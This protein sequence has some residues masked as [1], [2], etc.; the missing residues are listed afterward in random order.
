MKKHL[1]KLLV[2][3][4]AVLLSVAVLLPAVTSP[5]FAATANATAYE[6]SQ[7]QWHDVAHFAYDDE[8]PEYFHGMRVIRSED[9]IYIP[10]RELEIAA[11]H[12]G[13]MEVAA[14]TLGRPVGAVGFEG[15]YALTNP[16]EIVE[17]IVRFRT[18]PAVALRLLAE[19]QHPIADM[20]GMDGRMRAVDYD[21]MAL[22]AHAAFDSQLSGLVSP[23]GR[24][25]GVQIFARLHCLMN[26]VF[27]TVPAHMVEQIAGLPEVFAV[28]PNYTFYIEDSFEHYIFIDPEYLEYSEY[29]E[30]LEYLEYPEY[31]E[32]PEYLE[33][34]EYPEY[35]NDSEY[36]E[37]PKYPEYPEYDDVPETPTP[38]AP[39][40]YLWEI[41]PVNPFAIVDLNYEDSAELAFWV[42]LYDPGETV[43]YAQ[44]TWLFTDA[45]GQVSVVATGDFDPLYTGYIYLYLEDITRDEAG[46]YLLA[47]DYILE[48]EDPESEHGENT[49]RVFGDPI[50]L[51][52]IEAALATLM[53]LNDPVV[54]WSA[55]L[56]YSLDYFDI[57]AFRAMGLTG[58]G[59]R[60]GVVDSGIDYNHPM[61]HSQRT[62]VDTGVP[63][64]GDNGWIYTH[65][66]YD[67]VN[68]QIRAIHGDNPPA[69]EGLRPHNF[70]P[71]ETRPQERHGWGGTSH[72]TH[73]QGIIAAVAPE[74]TFY[75]FRALA[76]TPTSGGGSNVGASVPL[77]IAAAFAADVDVMNLSIGAHVNQPF[78]A[79][80]AMVNLAAMAGVTVVIAAGNAGSW[81]WYSM[82][83]PGVA[84]LP[85][86]VGA[87]MF[88]GSPFFEMP[89]FLVD[90][91]A[92]NVSL[93]GWGLTCDITALGGTPP[94]VWGW[95][96]FGFL[97][98]M[99]EAP[100]VGFD[101]DGLPIIPFNV[102]QHWVNNHPVFGAPGFV[103]PG[104]AV[105]NRGE[106]PLTAIHYFGY[107]IGSH[108]ILIADDER[109]SLIGGNTLLHGVRGSNRLPIMASNFSTTPRFGAAG[110]TGTISIGGLHAHHAPDRISGFS[111]RGPV[112]MTYHIKPDVVAPG[113]R[114]LSAIPGFLVGGVWQNAFGMSSGTSMAAPVVAGFAALLI[115]HE[116]AMGP[117]EVKAR[118]M[119]T[120]RDHT[121]ELPHNVSIR[122]TGAGFIQPMRALTADAFA[123]VFH[124]VPIMEEYPDDIALTWPYMAMSSMSFG[125]HHAPAEYAD[126]YSPELTVTIRNPGGT[127]ASQTAWVS[128]HP[129]VRLERVSSDTSN[130]AAHTFTYRMVVEW[131]AP[132]GWYDG[133]LTF[134]SGGQS[135]R[136]PFAIMYRPE[137]LIPGPL[138]PGRYYGIIRSIISGHYTLYEGQEDIRENPAPNVGQASPNNAGLSLVS[139]FCPMAP[140][141][142]YGSGS[143]LFARSLEFYAV[144]VYG[145]AAGTVWLYGVVPIEPNTVIAFMNEMSA[146]TVGG[147]VIRIMPPGLYELRVYVHCHFSD[148]AYNVGFPI[149]EFIISND[150]P[151][152]IFDEAV[153]TH[154]GSGYATV[155]GRVISP[156]KDWAM[157]LGYRLT[158][159][160]ARPDG[161]T[162]GVTPLPETFY[163]WERATRP[164]DYT[165]GWF[166]TGRLP[167]AATAAF[168]PIN[169]DGTFSLEI[170]VPVDFG[171]DG[172]EPWP[173]EF[174]YTDAVVQ[175]SFVWGRS[176]RSLPATFY[177][178]HDGAF[179]GV[180][181]AEPDDL[182][183]GFATHHELVRALAGTRP[184]DLDVP[185]SWN[186]ELMRTHPDFVMHSATPPIGAYWTRDGDV[187]AVV[188]DSRLML[189]IQAGLNPFDPGPG[190]R[191]YAPLTYIFADP[192]LPSLAVEYSGEYVLRV[193]VG[194]PDTGNYRVF[195]SGIVELVITEAP[196]RDYAVTISPQFANLDLGDTMAFTAAVFEEGTAM[197]DPHVLWRLTDRSGNPV[198][199]T[200]AVDGSVATVTVSRD[201]LLS[202]LHL[203]ATSFI[204]PRR[205]AV[206]V[207]NVNSPVIVSLATDPYIQGLFPGAL[208]TLDGSEH[209][210]RRRINFLDVEPGHAN[211][212]AHFPSGVGGL[213]VTTFAY[214][215]RNA[216]RM[217][218]GGN[219][220][221]TGVALNTATLRDRLEPGAYYEIYVRGRVAIGR[222]YDAAQAIPS[223]LHGMALF[224]RSGEANNFGAFPLPAPPP[225][226]HGSNN[227]S[228]NRATWVPGV[229][230]NSHTAMHPLPNP[231]VAATAQVGVNNI[232]ESGGYFEI[233]YRMSQSRLQTLLDGDHPHDFFVVSTANLLGTNSPLAFMPH[234]I[235]DFTLTRID[236]LPEYDLSLPSLADRFSGHFSIGNVMHDLVRYDVEF[237][238]QNYTPPGGGNQVAI[239]VP[240]HQNAMVADLYPINTQQML[241]HHYSAVT[242]GRLGSSRV[243]IPFDLSLGMFDALPNN[244]NWWF[245][246]RFIE[247]AETND[248]DAIW[249]EGINPAFPTLAVATAVGGLIPRSREFTLGY[250]ELFLEEV[251]RRYD[252]RLSVMYVV[253]DAF[254]T[255]VTA[256]DT[257]DGWRGALRHTIGATQGGQDGISNRVYRVFAQ[258]DGDGADWIWYSFKLA[259]R[260]MPNVTL[261]ISDPNLHNPVVAQ[262]MRD[263]VAEMNARWA[264]YPGN[265]QPGRPLIEG[266]AMTTRISANH[267]TN[268]ADVAADMARILG[269]LSPLGIN[270]A[271]SALEVNMPP[272]T[273]FTGSGAMM[274]NLQAE[275]YAALFTE[276]LNFSNRIS[277]VTF[278]SHSDS[279]AWFSPMGNPSLFDA[280]LAPKPAFFSILG[281][282][283]AVTHELSF[284]L[285]AAPTVPASILPIQV[286][287][288]SN[289]LAAPGFPAP[290]TREGYRFVGWY[291]DAGLTSRV[292]AATIMPP[293]SITLFA[294]WAT[295]PDRELRFDLGGTA[296]APTIPGNIA[297]IFIPEG[298]LILQAPGFPENP[299]REGYVFRGWYMNASRTTP[300]TATTVMPARA[301]TIFAAWTTVSDREQLPVPVVTLT[302]TIIT[303]PVVPY[304]TGYRV[305]VNGVAVSGV[306]TATSFN[307]AMLNLAE[308]TYNVQVRAIGNEVQHLDSALSAAV[309]FAVQGQVVTPPHPP[310]QFPPVPPQQQPPV[311]PQPP[312]VAPS[313]PW[314]PRTPA[315]N[316]LAQYDDYEY[317]EVYLEYEE[318]YVE[319]YAEEATEHEDVIPQP[320]NKLIFTVGN[321]EYLLNGNARISVGAPFIDVATDRMMIPLRTLSEALGVE[322]DWDSATR[323]AIV[324]LPAGTLVIPVDE[325]LPD[326]MGSTILVN[327]RAFI[328]LRFVMYAFDA[329]VEWDSANRAAIITW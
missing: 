105:V 65:R 122:T 69:A 278:F 125:Y 178:A 90:G 296:Q 194:D 18:P 291:M 300:V 138:G 165:M 226:V 275:I 81:G 209:F 232:V 101:E 13:E 283:P 131:G 230:A 260:Q 118:L 305:Y 326:G 68:H 98:A 157:E 103:P 4:L 271:I 312:A 79:S 323:S 187:V 202:V 302:G 316:V 63:G 166:R 207:I 110:T 82:A 185:L 303:W 295:I 145:P 155:T 116:P 153:F 277:H 196:D 134:T 117:Y 22:A 216:L 299:V 170:P 254:M 201:E 114:I 83:T 71:M 237:V 95:E 205:Y 60:I 41:I 255:T 212:Y 328:P 223:N 158:F 106:L 235:F 3:T 77:A 151:E 198:V 224:S 294:S 233:R 147:G 149:G 137:P 319:G 123:T 273:V 177:L 29:P 39:I 135:I 197:A 213:F 160:T 102:V 133:I 88:T 28:T 94:R 220:H 218:G 53:P 311:P 1:K 289:I 173:Q 113:E 26:A 217:E 245:Y 321:I 20:L 182:S 40:S 111:S 37:Y 249:R 115:E 23:F 80:N 317:D 203:R 176:N 127:W 306:I 148:G 43:L 84:S 263:M 174:F 315:G 45:Y 268:P 128:G 276:F 15:D 121:N 227:Y 274:L 229:P 109:D 107:L 244:G 208:T 193:V 34:P 146:R 297:S 152:V 48:S 298:S 120:A 206:A 142:W 12:A 221:N 281:A 239:P 309:V 163:F 265:T 7:E 310:I 91:T 85:I 279:T 188:R 78:S 215:G 181:A 242:L 6:D 313:T 150:R 35:P 301:L 62:M 259:R 262:A 59:I 211:H 11:R 204:D 57:D 58:E 93:I 270:I 186:L 253:N 108:A 261:Y 124:S 322:V 31:P 287:E 225:G 292:T 195:E 284:S 325:M 320:Q 293:R 329:T 50:T 180:R 256:D 24:T 126:T 190:T 210:G 2:K 228:V 19:A 56:S 184:L 200:L 269:I 257:Q 67:F 46:A 8:F 199:S 164:W 234:Y 167:F 70:S 5:A 251:G 129:L 219:P 96:N 231:F 267:L 10:G 318:Y 112:A 75:H 92:A 238:A 179:D 30:D 191:F 285:G 189:F 169:P 144:G 74:A 27:M 21:A 168:F 248:M 140:E 280:N 290:P 247:F 324:F 76:P 9:L 252:G 104:I 286:A 240:V 42:N 17:I 38:G 214:D 86:T 54:D 327:D 307:L 55:V 51:H 49:G 130:P 66:G 156:A 143:M 72:G 264:D 304:A 61:F 33:Y 52:V 87:S 73:V 250:M 308:G 192:H 172:P 64:V 119:N 183:V 258:D 99:L 266:I 97:E 222:V 100:G 243:L 136:V 47:I 139:Y 175:E 141:T 89:T 282:L 154:D 288:F 25:G 36:P 272:A 314:A 159:Y 246:D 14:Y 162:P 161:P 241:A 236:S 16:N 32:D 171:M 44:Y 132:A